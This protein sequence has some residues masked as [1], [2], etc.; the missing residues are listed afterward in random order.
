MP[1]TPAISNLPCVKRLSDGA[2]FVALGQGTNP[3]G[4]ATLPTTAWS[5]VPASEWVDCSPE[6]AA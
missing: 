2:L 1:A 5:H 4:W 6:E 3:T